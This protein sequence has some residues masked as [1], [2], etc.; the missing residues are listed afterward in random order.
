MA[1]DSK[2]IYYLKDL[3]EYK[4]STDYPDIRG[5]N[6]ADAENRTFGKVFDL[7]VSKQDERAVYMD[8]V[9]DDNALELDRE[10]LET[11]GVQTFA[12]DNHDHLVFP[13]GM[14]DLDEQR[15]KVSTRQITSR[16]FM[17]TRHP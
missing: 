3:A 7:L 12:R 8:V 15:K 16:S 10:V 14:A 9:V 11:E 4:I 17:R 6:V 13:I 5:W 2:D 1:T